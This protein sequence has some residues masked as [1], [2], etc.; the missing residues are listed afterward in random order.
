MTF[1]PDFP[2]VMKIGTAHAG[3]GKMRI[4]NQSDYEDFRSVIALQGRYVTSEPFI[5]WDYDIRIQKIGNNYRAFK[6]VSSNWKGSGMQQKDEDIKVE[7]RYKLW[8]DK[9]SKAIGMDICA[10]DG[11]HDKKSGKEFIL[12]LNDSAIGLVK[13]HAKEDI[14]NIKNLVLE[15]MSSIFKS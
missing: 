4:T 14:Q 9:A 13:R 12:E 8:V 1:P 2:T 3:F 11:V 15:R 10:L 6:R 5:D 7:D